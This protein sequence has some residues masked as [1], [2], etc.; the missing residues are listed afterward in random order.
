L[1]FRSNVYDKVEVR[2]EENFLNQLTVRELEFARYLDYTSSKTDPV[3]DLIKKDF[4]V[5]SNLL[6]ERFSLNLNNALP[7]SKIVLLIFS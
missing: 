7:T 1:L 2:V 4:F 3:E 5:K 6:S